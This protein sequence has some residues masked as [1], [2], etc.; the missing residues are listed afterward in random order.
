MEREAT[1]ENEKEKEKEEVEAME[2][3]RGCA[4]SAMAVL[5]DGQGRWM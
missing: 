2:A 4:K 5:K 3:S 1:E